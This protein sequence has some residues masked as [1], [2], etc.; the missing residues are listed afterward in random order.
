[1]STLAIRGG[2]PCI[3]R[4]LRPWLQHARSVELSQADRRAAARAVKAYPWTWDPIPEFERGWARYVGARHCVA[5]NSGTAALQTA[6][7]CIGLERGDEVITSAFTFLASASCVLYQNGIPVFADIDPRTYCLDPRDVARRITRKTRAIIPVHICGLPADMDAINRLA[8][9]HGLAVIEDACQAHGALYKGKQAGTV[10]D[11]GCFSL[12]ES[13]NLT[14]AYHGGMLVTDRDDYAFV[15]GAMRQFGEVVKPD[16]R[17]D[18]N[19]RMLGHMFRIDPVRAAIAGSRLKRLDAMNR[20]RRRQCERLSRRLAGIPGVITPYVP[21]DRTH[22]YYFY[23][24]RFDPAAAG[25]PDVPRRQFRETVAKALEAE[26][27]H[28]G[29]WQTMPV[30]QQE[31]IAARIGYGKGC[32]WTCPH[33]RRVACDPATYPETVKLME[34]YTCLWCFHLHDRPELADAVADAF[35]KVF[36][37]LGTLFKR[38]PTC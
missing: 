4:R 19:A 18:Y 2:R 8:R 36:A 1:M 27:V 10:G 12:Q 25:Y 38:G 28:I 11:I 29:Q 30:P 23:P 31:V 33:A 14:G 37:N 22:V 9:R 6:L 16:A 3:P 26:G 17:R 20:T 7:K 35:E 32:P 21:S 15:A 34:D 5:M 24:V 13:K